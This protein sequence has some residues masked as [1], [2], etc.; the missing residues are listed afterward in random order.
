M[1]SIAIKQLHSIS[2]ILS[3]NLSIQVSNRE[4]SLKELI[5]LSFFVLKQCITWCI[6]MRENPCPVTNVAICHSTRFS[7]SVNPKLVPTR[8][9]LYL[10]PVAICNPSWFF[11]DPIMYQTKGPN[12]FFFSMRVTRNHLHRLFFPLQHKLFKLAFIISTEYRRKGNFL[13]L[14]PQKSFFWVIFLNPSFLVLFIVIFRI[15]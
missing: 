11:L 3:S 10:K 12:H 7:G 1:R 14:G 2:C 15:R 13:Q 8:D 6:V 9:T 5:P 4:V